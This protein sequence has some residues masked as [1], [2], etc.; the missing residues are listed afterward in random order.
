MQ[1]SSSQFGTRDS[2][3]HALG[4][5]APPPL[6]ESHGSQIRDALATSS[7][8]AE[9]TMQARRRRSRRSTR[10]GCVIILVC[11]A[12]SLRAVANGSLSGTLA[13]PSGAVVPGAQIRL[14]NTALRSEF[15][16]ISDGQ[17]FYSFPT[18]PV[19]RYDLNIEAAGF[20]TQRKTNLTVDTDAALKVDAVLDWANSRTQ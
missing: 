10:L 16:T 4:F 17:G 20:K 5:C 12:V 18:L 19:G 13:D 11:S 1:I 8:G 9:N 2:T 6:V 15:K 7:K 14:V 3:H